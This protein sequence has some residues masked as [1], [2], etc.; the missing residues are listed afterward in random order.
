MRFSLLVLL[1]CF[2]FFLHLSHLSSLPPAILDHELRLGLAT[3]HIQVPMTGIAP[4]AV[5]ITFP[6]VK[7]FGMTALAIRFP[8]ALFGCL[9]IILFYF[10]ALEI[11]LFLKER[12]VIMASVSHERIF[13]FFPLL[14]SLF[15]AF[16]PWHI[17]VARMDIGIQAGFFF[18]LLGLYLLLKFSGS[19]RLPVLWTIPFV[20]S[21]YADYSFFLPS[22]FVIF[23]VLFL[24]RQSLRQFPL[25]TGGSIVLGFLLLLPLLPHALAYV[26][27][28]DDT[29]V[30][31]AAENEHLSQERVLYSGNT[32]LS[33][34]LFA[35]QVENLKLFFNHLTAYLE[36]SQLFILWD[37]SSSYISPFSGLL[38]PTD[39]LFLLAGVFVLIQSSAA[40]FLLVLLW[41]SVVLLPLAFTTSAVD[42]LRASL[43]LPIIALLLSF[44]SLSLLIRL[45][46]KHRLLAS[47]CTA[48]VF[49]YFFLRFLYTYF[50]VFPEKTI[51]YPQEYAQ[52]FRY[53][54][55]ALQKTQ[56]VVVTDV[57]YGKNTYLSLLFMSRG[58][59]PPVTASPV[60]KTLTK[61]IAQYGNYSFV[62]EPPLSYAKRVFYVQPSQTVPKR[63][64]IIL[65]KTSS[66]DKKYQITV[67]TMQ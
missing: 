35:P 40:I 62:S 63:S 2:S 17:Q 3:Q 50:V 42:P 32:E 41:A 22:V 16:S 14:A 10:F 29:Y 7:L 33:K 28:P 43:L 67:F 46:K 55:G 26:T 49:A 66:P 45:P 36:P 39:L 4:L 60:Q 12:L 53:T 24:K 64:T 48:G 25:F 18:F 31:L 15:F 11:Y 5:L 59:L 54:T 8:S 65:Y 61:R 57:T 27:R 20:L 44:G 23:S 19:L 58:V 47:G 30:Y 56:P 21:V 6:F 52:A 13:S 34:L 9:G 51:D 1:I 37:K 38:Y